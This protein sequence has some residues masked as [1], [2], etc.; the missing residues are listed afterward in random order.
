[1]KLIVAYIQSHALTRAEHALLALPRLPGLTVCEVRGFGQG[2][3]GE[4]HTPR[5]QLV[6]F[7]PKLRLEVAVLD[8]D[9]EGVV[10]AIASAAH[11]GRRGD[12]KILVLDLLD[13]RRIRTGEAGPDA[14]VSP[15]HDPASARPP[16]EGT[17]RGPSAAG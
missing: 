3:A 13:A 9:V 1:M 4:P 17:E 12:G 16:G 15:G 2:K 10:D 8:E 11:S 5:E 6:E 7:T 14:L